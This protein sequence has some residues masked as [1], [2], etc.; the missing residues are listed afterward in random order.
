[1]NVG[2]FYN[3]ITNPQKFSNK[4]MLMD[5]FAQGVVANGD[6]VVKYT[7]KVLPNEKL[8]AG[9]VL[10]YTLEQNFRRSIIDH[11]RD[12]NTPVVF[13][14]SNI[15]HY[16][17]PTHEW[18]RYSINGVY[19]GSGVYFF[20]GIKPKWEEYSKWHGVEAKPL[21]RWGDHILLLAQRP[22]GWNMLG[23]N[24]ADWINETIRRIG[25]VSNR[26]IRVR[27]HP[28]DDT[29][30]RQLDI[31]KARW[32]DRVQLVINDNIKQ[33]LIDCWAAVGYNSTPNVVAAIEGIPVYVDDPQ[34]SWASDIAFERLA[35]IESPTLPHRTEWLEKI[36]NIHWSNEEVR[37]GRL[38]AAIKHYI[39]SAQK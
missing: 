10:G 4:V 30:K 24:Q 15:L 14:D 7:N 25:E 12:S 37:A 34:H 28:G 6:K 13:V 2:I 5:N 32:K 31:I 27:M 18:H 3:S 35:D 19:P 16:A 38:W 29:K 26:P 8:D 1:M 11:L 22:H 33:D 20:D 39:S 23:N 17:K 21:R 36:A 9:F